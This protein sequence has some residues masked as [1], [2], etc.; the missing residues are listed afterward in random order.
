MSTHTVN[1]IL[2]GSHAYGVPHEKSDIDLVV[3]MDPA[4]AAALATLLGVEI[5]R[6]GGYQTSLLGMGT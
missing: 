2:T 4:Q 6:D 3:F 5:D 1:A